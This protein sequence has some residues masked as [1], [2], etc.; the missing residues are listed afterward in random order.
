MKEFK[1][2]MEPVMALGNL[3]LHVNKEFR[4]FT[5][6]HVYGTPVVP[7]ERE[8]VETFL[9]RLNEVTDIAQHS[10]N[11]NGDSESFKLCMEAKL[12]IRD[13]DFII[14]YENEWNPVLSAIRALSER[15]HEEED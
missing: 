15:L 4:I 3:I 2:E 6:T 12:M 9:E 5:F 7:A 11:E 14:K 1:I 10:K 13:F 8:D